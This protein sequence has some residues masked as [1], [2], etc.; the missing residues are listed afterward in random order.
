MPLIWTGSL[1]A[2][3]SPKRRVKMA[4][5]IDIYDYNRKVD[6]EIRSIEKSKISEKNKELIF[7]FKDFCF[8]E[9][10]SKARVCRLLGT[11]KLTALRINKD[12][13]KATKEDMMEF[14]QKIQ[15]NENYSV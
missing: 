11:I 15:T 4:K 1:Y 10:L 8:I 2:S 3:T 5:R 13:D 7:Q 14:V 12:F 9:G 6:V